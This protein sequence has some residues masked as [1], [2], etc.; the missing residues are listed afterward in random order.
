MAWRY[1]GYLNCSPVE[2]HLDWF[3]F[4]VIA[5]RAV[6]NIHVQ[7]FAHVYSFSLPALGKYTVAV[8]GFTCSQIC[9]MLPIA[10]FFFLLRWFQYHT[11]FVGPWLLVI[12]FH[13]LIYVCLRLLFSSFSVFLW[14]FRETE[15]L[16]SFI[17]STDS[18]QNLH[19]HLHR[20]HTSAM[21]FLKTLYLILDC[22]NL[23]HE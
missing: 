19:L 2:R 3:Q 4:W 7:A 5:N 15:K 9:Q 11:G 6:M 21:W 17:V 16:C 14:E 1:H 22:Y 12:P 23:C 18:T 8:L 13:V 10:S 20:I